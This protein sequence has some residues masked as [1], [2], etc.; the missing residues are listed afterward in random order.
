MPSSAR[1]LVVTALVA[2]FLAS[3]PF[4]ARA[5]IIEQI[6]VKVNGEI[7]TKTDL[8]ARQVG[9]IRQRN[10]QPANDAELKKLITDI[11]PQLLV[12]TVDEMLVL[13]R[14]K[15]LG[16]HLTDTQ[17]ETWLSNVKKENHLDTDEQLQAA[18]KQENMTLADLRKSVDRN[19]IIDQVQ[20]SEVIGRID[21]TEP[22]ERK[23]YDEHSADFTTPATLSVREILL[24]TP[25]DAKGISVGL[26]EETKQKAE[27]LRAQL[28]AGGS[29][30][31][32]VTDVSAAP[33]KANGGLVG[34]INLT[35][36]NPAIASQ[37][38]PLKVGDIS[39]VV[40]VQGG[41]ELF[42]IETLT[43]PTVLS[44]EQARTQIA[45]QIINQRRQAEF[46]K[47]IKKLRAAAII[48]WKNPELQ[49]LY[50][51]QVKKAP[52]TPPGAG[53]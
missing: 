34:P 26:D 17:F 41:Y 19:F 16:Y 13:Q 37:L 7:F 43:V 33:S 49:K 5:E 6:L 32:A 24:K 25:S 29:F 12:D 3:L 40:P 21:I 35:E 22:E 9:V 8:E 20:R 42:K 15:E 23:F 45:D 1:R 11:T 10:L 50:E 52:A 31:K 2:G 4:A 36:L 53:H 18:L 46:E 38:K 39:Q 28:V 14:G 47:Y 51:E 30:E 48:E 44:F 27:A